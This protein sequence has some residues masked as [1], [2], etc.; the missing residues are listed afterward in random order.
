[1]RLETRRL[2]VFVPVAVVLLCIG[3]VVAYRAASDQ[4]DGLGAVRRATDR[5]HDVAVAGEAQYAPFLDVDG[6]ACIDMPGMGAMGVHHVNQSLVGDADIDPL[7]PEAL[8]YEP[9]G[10]GAEHLAAVE[11]LVVKSAWDS[12]HPAPPTLFGRTFD[13]S[14]SPNRF[15]LPAFYSL[16]AWAW[17]HNP[18][19]TFSMWNPTV[20]CTSAAGG[21]DHEGY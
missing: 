17:E 8:V 18:T 14:T 11:Y 5:F 12:A 7:Q 15:G 9:D 3:G 1:M 6:I 16:H 10:D 13:V 19:G 2:K 4:S 20:H 21:H